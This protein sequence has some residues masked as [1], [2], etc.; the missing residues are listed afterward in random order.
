MAYGLHEK[1]S[2]GKAK[3]QAMADNIL[4]NFNFL[5]HCV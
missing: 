2:K 1:L 3:D 4:L 5:I